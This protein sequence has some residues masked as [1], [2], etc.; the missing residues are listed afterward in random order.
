MQTSILTCTPFQVR[1]IGLYI[2]SVSAS[3]I[4]IIIEKSIF[5]EV[6]SLRTEL[7][8]LLADDFFEFGSSGKI[9]NKGE[10]IAEDGI[11]IVR[12]TWSDF[13]L[14]LLSE[15]IVLSTYRIINEHSK[16]YSLRSSI[17]GSVR[18]MRI[19]TVKQ[20]RA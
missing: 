20:I 4:S 3:L 15:S 2:Y 7:K 5:S 12:M 17:W 8:K 14:H 9:L 6:C 19:Y 10:D 16:Q 13:E 11:R 1:C 18:K